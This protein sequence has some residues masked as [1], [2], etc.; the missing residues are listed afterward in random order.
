[1]RKI[2]LLMVAIALFAG[3]F[4][5]L[6]A[7]VSAATWID[8]AQ[9]DKGIV[10]VTYPVKSNVSTKVMIARGTEKYTYSLYGA[11]TFPLQLGNGKYEI[12]VLEHVSGKSYKR[13]A[14]QEVVLALGADQQVFL[15]SVQ[16]V[17]WNNKNAAIIKAKELTKNLKTD[18]EKVK[19]I[20]E[21]VYKTIN[22]DNKLAE[23]VANNY[24]PNI[25][26]TL[27]TKLAICYD[28]STLTA[29]ML[30]S[31][32]IPAKLVMGQ[33]AYVD[34]YHAWNEVF[35]DGKWVIIDT[36]VDAGLHKNGKKFQMAK[37]ASKYKVEKVY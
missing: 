21:Y 7:E 1:M 22:Y 15:N 24:I 12:S 8:V 30:R 32:D 13:V 14:H 19:A 11:E 3:L 31:V 18:A 20:Y 34:V 28:Y 26:S 36:T 17:K 27:K 37:E 35:V 23:T 25:D 6:T 33:S 16:N 2:S 10:K 9:V 4:G 29:A 5:N